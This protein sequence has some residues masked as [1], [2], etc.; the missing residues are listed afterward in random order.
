M[1]HITTKKQPGVISG[2]QTTENGPI[3][4]SRTLP[5][6]C[7]LSAGLKL[8]VTPLLAGL[9][10]DTQKRMWSFERF[11]WE[12]QHILSKKV[13]HVFHMNRASS[14]EI[15]LDSDDT[16][17]Q[18]KEHIQL[19]TEVPAE[20]QLMLLDEELLEKRLGVNSASRGYP[21]TAILNPIMLYSIDNN[22]VA[23]PTELELP[24]F[25]SFPAG[26]S[27]ENDASLAKVSYCFF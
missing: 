8:L 19:Q 25:P 12:V 3:E 26:V 18:L 10:E 9:L 22:N 1:H 15:F 13:H 11:F 5:P 2:T 7:Q 27:V 6:H 14:I 4:W 20:S 16:I 23:L 21:P 24:K 17:H